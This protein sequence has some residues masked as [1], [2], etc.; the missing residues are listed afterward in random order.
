MTGWESLQV[1]AGEIAWERARDA[2]RL[3]KAHAHAGIAIT[4]PDAPVLE[5]TTVLASRVF[6]P[7]AI[8]APCRVVYGADEPTRFGFAYG[9]LPGHPETGEEA[10]HVFRGDDGI[11]MAEIRA[12]SRP[13]GLPTKRSPA[14]GLKIQQVATRRYLSGIERYVDEKR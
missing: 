3:W 7:V 1:G 5:G 11:V 12:F 6:G 14:R 13:D 2:I 10:F 9:T 8:L 4:P